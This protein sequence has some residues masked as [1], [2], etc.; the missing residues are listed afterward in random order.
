MTPMRVVIVGGGVSG[1]ALAFELRTRAP[2]MP[3]TV[4]ER[5]YTG[6]GDSSRN[7]GRIRAMQLTPELTA[8]ALAAQRKH[9]RLSDELR[10]NTLFWRSGYAW[11]LYEH[12]ELERMEGLLPMYR[13]LGMR[14]PKVVTGRAL[15]RRLPIL[16]GGE[17]PAGAMIGH[18]AIGHHDAVLY[19]YRPACEG[20]GVDILEHERVTDV[21]IDGDAVTGVR[22]DRKEFNADVV[23]NAAGGGGAEIARAA[24][25]E[26]PVRNRK[27][28]I[29]TFDCQDPVP[30]CPLLIDPTGVHV[31]PEGKGFIC[32]SAPPA[33]QDPDS[34][35]FE[36]EYGF[37]DEAIWPV[38]AGRVP[39]FE[40][41]RTGRAWAGHYDMNLFDHNA[42]VG[43][44]PGLDNF[45]LANGFS[46][47]GLQQSPAVGRGLAEL[48]LEGRFRSLDLTPLSF[49]R[50][51]ENRPMIESNVV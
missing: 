1:L 15:Q 9:E 5:S 45:Y 21:L 20:L 34:D 29:F 3:V 25:L 11:V 8:F 23:V 28:M 18:D 32:G 13:S 10:S 46:G 50:L 33:D 16:E 22:T 38:L 4:L 14:L 17:S 48:I 2:E 44:A 31:R 7:V 49:D 42:F 40:R 19:A 51:L 47:H 26:I 39:A 37:F 6:S 35:D 12:D 30:N 36:V 43:P 24:G 27:R 41:I